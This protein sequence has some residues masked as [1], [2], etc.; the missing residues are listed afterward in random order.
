MESRGQRDRKATAGPRALPGLAAIRDPRVQRVRRAL[1]AIR[2]LPDLEGLP[3]R[4]AR[5][6][7]ERRGQLA[8]KAVMEI[9]VL[10]DQPD[11]VAIRGP[12]VLL[13]IQ[14]L[15]VQAETGVQLI[16]PDPRGRMVATG[17]LARAV[18]RAQLAQT[19]MPGLRGQRGLP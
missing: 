6:E 10:Q 11:L 4:L 2:A 8:L 7:R 15:L 13:E 14:D 18:R 5:K 3:V 9:L 16:L 17:R 1:M 19:A 12:R